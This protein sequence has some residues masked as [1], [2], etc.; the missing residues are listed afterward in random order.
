MIPISNLYYLLCYAWKRLDERD[1]VDIEATPFQDLP[2]LLARV[3]IGG[4]KRL[5]RQGFDRDYVSHQEDLQSPKGKIDTSSSIKRALLFRNSVVCAFDELSRNVLHNQIIRATLYR[6][7]RTAG[8]DGDLSHELRA[9]GRQL[10]GVAL[11]EIRADHFVRVQLHRNNAFYRFLLH[12][13]ELCFHALLADETSGE[14][15]FRDFV[16]D[17]ERMRKVFQDFVFNF[18]DVEQHEF[19][20]SSERLEWDVDLLD[21]NAEMLLPDMITDV[22]LSSASRKIVI[23]CKFTQETLQKNWGKL[24]VRSEHLYQLF[25]YL[26]NLEGRGGINQSCDGLLL[27]PATSHSVDF[28]FTIHGHPVRI[29]TLDLTTNWLDIRR[30]MLSFLEPWKTTPQQKLS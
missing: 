12:V 23:E 2:N 18:F 20:V 6:L 24:S 26:K 30:R 11:I 4:I 28:A 13:C 21:A 17:E 8:I 7:A 15:R 16:R 10:E 14:Y 29:A 22:C 3:L 27:Y 25:S 5:L 1:F 9:L 19:K